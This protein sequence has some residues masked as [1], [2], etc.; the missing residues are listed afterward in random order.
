MKIFVDAFLH[1]DINLLVLYVIVGPSLFSRL[2]I[3]PIPTP[4]GWKGRNGG[5]RS[6]LLA[7]FEIGW[8]IYMYI[9]NLLFFFFFCKDINN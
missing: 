7:A 3:V 5:R 2:Q 4:T 9:F 1:Y 8:P 6:G